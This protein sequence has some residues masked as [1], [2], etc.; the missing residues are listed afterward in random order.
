MKICQISRLLASTAPSYPRKAM[1]QGKPLINKVCWLVELCK[2][3]SNELWH[4][5]NNTDQSL[6]PGIENHAFCTWNLFHW[7]M[8]DQYIG[9]NNIPISIKQVDQ[10]KTKKD[11]QATLLLRICDS[12]IFLTQY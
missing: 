12:T 7:I 1:D 11:K 6:H 10:E 2:F 4:A 8:E 5:V 3:H 9:R